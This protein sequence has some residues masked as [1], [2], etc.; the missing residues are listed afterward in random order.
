MWP[1]TTLDGLL[2]SVSSRK[3]VSPVLNLQVQPATNKATID[4]RFEL[5]LSKPLGIEIGGKLKFEKL[6]LRITILHTY[7]PR[8]YLRQKFRER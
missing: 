3:V 7:S 6:K 4:N 8:K 5:E 2:S 1:K